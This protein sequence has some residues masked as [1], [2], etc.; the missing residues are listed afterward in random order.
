ML[1]AHP[2]RVYTRDELLHLV[3]DAAAD[4]YD[5]TVDALVKT[6]RAKMRAVA[7]GVEAILTSRGTGYALSDELPSAPT[8]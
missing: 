2:G 8:A 1:A 4:S 5:R 6:L 7:P 3:W